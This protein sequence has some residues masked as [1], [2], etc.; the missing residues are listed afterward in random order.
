MVNLLLRL[1]V[2]DTS[3]DIDRGWISPL[4][5]LIHLVACLLE[6]LRKVL[7]ERLLDQ[8]EIFRA[9]NA[10]GLVDVIWQ[11]LQTCIDSSARTMRKN[12]HV[13]CIGDH[14]RV[15]IAS[16]HNSVVVVLGRRV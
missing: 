14:R 9:V 5:L 13:H 3:W 16:L 8:G 4:L 15:R 11:T 2:L 1:V 10:G 6:V 12:A 7:G